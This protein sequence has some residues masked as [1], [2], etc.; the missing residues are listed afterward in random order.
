M[1]D[2]LQI[3]AA[4]TYYQEQVKQAELATTYM[5]DETGTIPVK[6]R[7]KDK[8]AVWKT[9]FQQTAYFLLGKEGRVQ[10]LR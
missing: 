2:N 1:Y 7:L 10:Q 8:L 3:Q 9:K 6:P 4:R 5:R